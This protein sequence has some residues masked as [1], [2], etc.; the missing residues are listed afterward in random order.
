MDTSNLNEDI[1]NIENLK[2]QLS[3]D[4]ESKLSSYSHPPTGLKAFELQ[5][6]I[7]KRQ[8]GRYLK[9]QT[10]PH[11]SNLLKI[12]Q[13]IT[14]EVDEQRLMSI[15]P[16]SIAKELRKNNPNSFPKKFKQD[17]DFSN[18]MKN[19]PAFT[20]IY[21][22]TA[23]QGIISKSDIELEFGQYGL[24]TLSDMCNKNI[25][26]HLGN[27]NYSSG[28]IRS[29]SISAEAGKI[30]GQ[31][32]LT[33]Y[34]RPEASSI[35]GENLLGH[36]IIRLDPENWNIALTKMVECYQEIN[37]LENKNQGDRQRY[38]MLIGGDKMLLPKK[39]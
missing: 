15:S 14:G 38:F 9:K 11:Y 27:G 7:S 16:K 28:L 1:N 33:K 36:N 6:G 39:H 17:Q 29:K 24:S 2:S 23:E 4:L 37:K 32:L 35:E 31:H 18:E 30:V 12:Y 13:F 21:W 22:E 25:I 8:I 26:Q 20:F 3:S 34:H 10:F 5:T 19:N